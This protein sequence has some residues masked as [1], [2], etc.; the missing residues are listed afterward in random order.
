MRTVTPLAHGWRVHSAD[1]RPIPAEVP[2]TVH[3]D[4]LAA[5]LIPDPLVGDHEAE[6]AWI[7]ESDWRYT[8]EFRLDGED[9]RV[10]LVCEGLDTVAELTLNGKP[11]GSATNMHR[12]HRFDLRDALREGANELA[13]T[14]RSPVRYAQRM[15]DELGDRPGPY[16]EPFQF[17]RKA[18]CNFGWDWGPRYTTCG[19]WRPIGVHRWHTARLAEVRP[20]VT[21]DA[22][23]TGRVKLHV[24]VER[25]GSHELVATARIG[26]AHRETVTIP[27]GQREALLELTVGN[28]EL[29]WPRGHGEQPLYEVHV[30]LRAAEETL[31]LWER[32]IGIRSV[33][34]D[35]TPDAGGTPFTFR[36]NGKAI[37]VRGVNWIPDDVFF[38]RI[39]PGRYAARLDQACDAGVNLI[40]VWGGGIYESD[41]FYDAADERGLLVWQDFLFACAAYPEEE[42]LAGE[43]RAEAE[44]AVR[45]LAWHPSLVLW[46]GNNENIWGFWDWDWKDSLGGRTWGAGFY[47]GTLAEVV[48]RLDPARPYWPGS[49]YS[50]DPALHPNDPEHG[51]IHIW[52]VWND[53]DYED[54]RTYRPRFVAEFG[55]QGPP[56][57]RTALDG[58][59]V[60]ALEPDSP[61]VLTHQKAEN[62][63]E[64]LARGL[65]EHFGPVTGHDDWH[66]LTQL[67][68]ARAILLGV[69]HFRS[70][71][72]RCTGTVVW[73][74]NDCWPS[75][76]WAAIDS[77]GRRK[78]L[79]YALRNAHEDRRLTIQ[80]R[81]GGLAVA[82][83]NDTGTAW[84]GEAQVE[85]MTFGGAVLARTTSPFEAAPRSVHIGHLKADIA[86]AVDPAREL[87]VVT[88]GPARAVWF[89]AKDRL[90]A[91]PGPDFD[92]TA[93][94]G[95]EGS[96]VT[97]RARSLLRD[98]CLF[99]DRVTPD[100]VV[101]QAMVTVLPGGSATFRIQH[102]PGLDPAAFTTRPVLRCVN[103]VLATHP[104]EPAVRL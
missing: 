43:V 34:L 4:L 37:L 12:T 22:D 16:P 15:R 13:V 61:A 26:R 67:N 65:A 96:V 88:A 92:V 20:E 68:Q 84:S 55:Y 99:A 50:G 40:R 75:M 79:W 31:D 23:G 17:I 11:V 39:T 9:E 52:D 30:E 19:I 59:A 35:T 102:G 95:D 33:E 6:L 29:W 24:G 86:R 7:G 47:F 46:N 45:R 38:P 3:T 44:D 2:G 104:A 66:Y 98:L 73:Q 83:L 18:A 91:Y 82:V 8:C 64:K 58:F 28:P 90:L 103:D 10:D 25:T 85:R 57:H 54:Y 74:L 77:A 14:F 56:A 89:F 63:A 41:S 87:I 93:R 62:G 1:G 48:A 78:L 69:E 80:P 36:V 21:V 42:P 49:P 51:P 71:W 100:A 94:S 60:S 101:D 70:L 81:E 5:G 53:R 76:S 97:V 27:A 32:R 72:P